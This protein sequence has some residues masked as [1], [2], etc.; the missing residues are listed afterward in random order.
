VEPG[1]ADDEA[2]ELPGFLSRMRR[3]PTPRD[4]LYYRLIG[5]ASLVTGIFLITGPDLYPLLGM[6]LLL[7]AL[8]WIAA[9]RR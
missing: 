9:S 3:E 2:Y 7:I 8:L 4:I 1:T 5:G 6:L